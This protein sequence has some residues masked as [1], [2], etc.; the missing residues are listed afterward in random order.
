MAWPLVLAAGGPRT[1]GRA[2]GAQAA[3]RVQRSI[4]V[5]EEIFERYAELPWRDVRRHAEGFTGPLDAYDVE[6][7]PEVE[8]IAEGAGVDAEDV[9][10]I[11]LRT[12]IMFGLDARAA[13][14]AMKECTAAGGS[15]GGHVVVAQ[16]WD[17]KPAVRD[18]VVLLACAPQRGPGFVTLVE[19]GL[20]A[21]C[22]AS[23]VG[24]GLATNALQSSKDRGVPGVPYHAILRRILRSPSFEEATGAVVDASRSSSANYLI[25][26]SDGRLVNLEVAPGT[27]QDLHRTEGARLT[28]TNHFLWP[29]KPFEDVGLIDGEDSIVRRATA[30]ATT[31]TVDGIKHLLASHDRA[32]D[33]VCVHTTD[34]LPPV[35]D[36]VTV[37]GFLADLTE[38]TIEVTDGPPCSS[39]WAR[40]DIS[41]L[42]EA[43][44]ATTGP[45][46]DTSIP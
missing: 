27:R 46:P 16:N 10:A 9:L 40:H 39:P 24:V 19:A 45:T 29:G 35:E 37:G 18:T 28:H 14:V 26:H 42:V 36:Y 17:W 5:Y 6:L 7:L 38:G 20:W 1:R 2:Y 13:H 23:E 41:S 8:G 15:E 44:R 12:E 22:G 43:A 30:E 32:P 31:P 4:A 21:K 3:D 34:G 25:G 11:N 33:S